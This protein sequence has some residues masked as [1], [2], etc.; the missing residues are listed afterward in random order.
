MGGA[1]K[2]SCIAIPKD[3]LKKYPWDFSASIRWVNTLPQTIKLNAAIRTFNVNTEISMKRVYRMFST[4]FLSPPPPS[5][6]ILSLLCCGFFFGFFFLCWKTGLVAFHFFWFFFSFWWYAAP[7]QDW[8]PQEAMNGLLDCERNEVCILISEKAW[9]NYNLAGVSSLLCL[10]P[11]SYSVN[12]PWRTQRNI[13]FRFRA[14]L[15]MVE[16]PYQYC[17]VGVA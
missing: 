13:G 10:I 6:F 1:M 3:C 2:Q 5:S 8:C 7:T 4:F 9:S 12:N 11:L 17:T 15:R 16:S 14:V